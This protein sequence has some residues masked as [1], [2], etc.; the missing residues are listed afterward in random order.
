MQA[1]NKEIMLKCELENIAA[2]DSQSCGEHQQWYP[3]LA[4]LGT[5]NPKDITPRG[6]VSKNVFP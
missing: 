6:D 5:N 4:P 3:C 1:F 2:L